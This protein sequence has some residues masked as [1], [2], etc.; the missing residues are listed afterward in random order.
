MEDVVLEDDYNEKRCDHKFLC[1]DGGCLGEMTLSMTDKQYQSR[2]YFSKK[3]VCPICA[4]PMY[5]VTSHSS[6]GQ[7]PQ[8]PAIDYEH[9]G[10]MSS[11]GE[12]DCNYRGGRCKFIHTKNCGDYKKCTCEY[13][14]G[15]VHDAAIAQA[16]RIARVKS[17][18]GW[19]DRTG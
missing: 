4:G 15:V 1:E 10:N 3:A 2:F 18:G 6:T 9:C 12:H 13:C 16:A 8:E 11:D 5:E 17:L 7:H 14:T 19:D